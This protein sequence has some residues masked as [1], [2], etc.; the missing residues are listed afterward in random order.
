M[1]RQD[2]AESTTLAYQRFRHLPMK[3]ATALVRK[4]VR[5]WEQVKEATD[6]ELLA[7]DKI[8]KK[9]LAVIRQEQRYQG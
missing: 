5:S 8:G 9:S 1:L 4:G 3:V 7:L 2:Y 6:D